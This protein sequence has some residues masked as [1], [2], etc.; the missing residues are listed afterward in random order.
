MKNL[1]K[2]AFLGLALTLSVSTNAH[3]G[4]WGWRLPKPPPPPP[5]PLPKRNLAPEVDPSLA[6]SGLA[7][8]AGTLTV[9]RA[10][11]AKL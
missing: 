4:D 5:P 11:R 2:Y 7:L 8:L 9:V 1:L 3:A 6:I 10:R